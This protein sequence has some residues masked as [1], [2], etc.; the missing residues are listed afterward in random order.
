MG[1]PRQVPR[2]GDPARFGVRKPEERPLDDF[3]E[4]GGSHLL[5][6]RQTRT[7]TTPEH[8]PPIDD[9]VASQSPFAP[10]LNMSQRSLVRP[11]RNTLSMVLETCINMNLPRPAQDYWGLL[12]ARRPDG[13]DI[14]PDM[15]NYNSYLRLLRLQRASKL[16]VELVNDLKSGNVPV[17]GQ[18]NKNVTLEPKIF[19]ISMSACN[20]DKNNPHALAH[21][22]SLV[23]TMLATLEDVDAPTL[24]SYVELACRSRH[25][26]SNL[27]ALLEVMKEALPAW[28]NLKSLLSYH[29]HTSP[30]DKHQTKI[31]AQLRDQGREAARAMVSLCDKILAVGREELPKVEAKRVRAEKERF[32]DW[33]RRNDMWLKVEG[34]GEG[35]QRLSVRPAR[36]SAFAESSA[37]A[38]LPV[39]AEAEES[40][41]K[42][43]K[44]RKDPAQRTLRDHLQ[45]FSFRPRD[46]Y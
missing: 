46:R 16:T 31:R 3:L 20:R 26:K 27:T 6:A 40:W 42:G 7:D 14:V 23:R 4:D 34:E 39:T 2:L 11:S 43:L 24:C 32:G 22:S 36:S 28:R 21:A 37:P 15:E 5:P 25:S 30:T 29:P 17:F 45:S 41:P 8:L 18:A 19:R 1:L 38:K 33:L 35:Q 13:Y 10:I 9:H 12:T 44:G